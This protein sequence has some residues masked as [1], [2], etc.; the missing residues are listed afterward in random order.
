MLVKMYRE[1][2]KM[3][4]I[5]PSLLEA[6][7]LYL[8]D[9]ETVW[10]TTEK[11]VN[12]IKGDF[13]LTPPIKLGMAYHAMLEDNTDA[14]EAYFNGA[15]GERML[16]AWG[17]VD[18]RAEKLERYQFDYVK[19]IE[20]VSDFLRSPACVHEV[21]GYKTF[22][23]D[24]GEVSVATK[25]DAVVGNIGGEW[26][27]TEKYIQIM[28]YY[29]SVQ[30]KLTAWALNLVAI[31]YRVIQLVK[32][33]DTGIWTVKNYDAIQCVWSDS[34]MAEIIT[35]VNGLIDFHHTQGLE[36]Y[37]IPFYDRPENKVKHD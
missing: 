3:I 7:R 16:T 31:D 19:C 4:R 22:T 8:N 14:H 28:N 30:W 1:Y 36:H 25:A 29:D 24:Y 27:T 32:I 18:K 5:S 37:L 6:Y 2:R 21:K 15:S 12:Q 26:K 35:L 9:S 20:P 10:F 34:L 33:K 23:T 13:V 11:L 17:I